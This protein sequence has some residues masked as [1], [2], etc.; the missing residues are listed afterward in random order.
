[1]QVEFSSEDNP[2]QLAKGSKP[3]AQHLR[4]RHIVGT[5]AVWRGFSLFYIL[6]FNTWSPQHANP[7][8]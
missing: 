4:I 8:R 5:P 1:M 7:F 3:V 6:R 2:V